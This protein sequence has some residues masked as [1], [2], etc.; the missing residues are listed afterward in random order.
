MS[1]S[2]VF[3]QEKKKQNEIEEKEHDSHSPFSEIEKGL[4]SLQKEEES[5]E[6]GT[7]K[8]NRVQYKY[9]THEQLIVLIENQEQELTSERAQITA[10]KRQVLGQ[11]EELYSLRAQLETKDHLNE[12][13]KKQIEKLSGINKKLEEDNSTLFTELNTSLTELNTATERITNTLKKLSP[14]EESQEEKD[15][16]M[17]KKFWKWI[18]GK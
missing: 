17:P 15:H 5:G 13:Q 2:P 9:M 8:R 4:N 16:Y 7:E 3:T 1:S 18:R 11:H 14:E 12:E 6:K 10:V